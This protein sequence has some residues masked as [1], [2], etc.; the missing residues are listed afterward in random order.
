MFVKENPDI[1]KKKKKNPSNVAKDYIEKTVAPAHIIDN[2]VPLG[3]VH[4]FFIAIQN[5]LRYG[6][7]HIINKKLLPQ[8]TGSGKHLFQLPYVTRR[9]PE[10]LMQDLSI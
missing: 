6:Q 1:K 5:K 8:K 3:K 4:E 9:G 2:E 10:R 7:F